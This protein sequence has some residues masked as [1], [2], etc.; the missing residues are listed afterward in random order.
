MKYIFMILWVM[1]FT[2]TVPLLSAQNLMTDHPIVNIL[3]ATVVG[4][5]LG[6]YTIWWFGG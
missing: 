1:Y 6:S 5:I 2:T 3:L 4:I